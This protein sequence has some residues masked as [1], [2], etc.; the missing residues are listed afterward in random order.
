[1]PQRIYAMFFLSG[2]GALVFEN[3]WF[4]QTGLIVGNSVWSAALVVGAFMLG[5]ALGNAAAIPL[6]RRWRNLVRG[7]AAV[8]A[9]AALSGAL[10]VLAFPALPTLFRPLLAPL[11]DAPAML[12]LVR[13]A[14]AFCLMVIPATALG[15]TLPFLSKPLEALTGNYGSAIGRLYGVNTLGAVA[16]TLLAERFLI[17]SLG[18]LGGGLFAAACNL[19]AAFIALRL[20]RHPAF[21]APLSTDHG[22]RALSTTPGKRIVLAAFLAGGVLLALEVVWFRFLLLFQDGTTWNFAVML[23]V[24]LG[25]IGLGGLAASR[26]A[27]R[28]WSGGRAA[29]AAAAGAAVL[30]VAAYAAFDQ[31]LTLRAGPVVLSLFLMGPV[32]FLSGVLFTALADLLRERM[33][34][35]GAA[36]GVLTLANTLGATLGSLLAAF[37]LLPY[38]GLE[39]SFFLL[40]LSYG[41]TLVVIPGEAARVWRLGPALIVLVA[42]AL[43]PFGRM[44]G[45]YYGRV[46]E[47]FAGRLVAA[48]EGIE[49]TVFYLSHEFLG[50]PL[51]L[52]LATN[53]YSMAST[54]V[55]VQRYMKLFAYLPAAFHPRIER[56]LLLCFGVGTTASALTD[57]P[58][59]RSIDVVDTSRDIVE[60]SE[61]AHPERH[62]LRDPRVSVHIEDARFFLQQTDRRYDLITGEPP[63]PK[64]AGVTALYTRE[65]FALVKERLNPGGL[66]TYW[67]P[68]HLLLESEALSIIRAFCE[69][70]DDCSLWSG[71]N[72][73]WILAGSRDGI[74]P[75]SREHFSRL[76]RL[77][78]PASELRR[79]GIDRPEQL[80]G[81]FMADA[82]AL[83]ELT[84]A[85]LPLADN[86]PRRVT[87]ALFAERSTAR[88]AWLMDPGR[89]RERMLASSWSRILPASLVSESREGFRRRAILE[90]AFYPELR[91]PGYN[92]WS[93][94]AELIRGTDL[95]DLPRWLLGSGARAAEIA[96]RTGP[97]D[98]VAAEHRAIDA[99]ANRRP[100]DAMEKGRFMALTPE[101]QRVVVFHHCLAGDPVQARALM[102]SIPAERRLDALY[103]SLLSWADRQCAA[104]RIN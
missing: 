101:A 1:M 5:L 71:L 52:R 2:V 93:D 27:R 90:Q 37:V 26:W 92:F 65:Y 9:V 42:L 59:V 6:A 100:A 16:G 82:G 28:G 15:A 88:Y 75:V 76:W 62:P 19:S 84:A 53:S 3:V 103:L 96:A 33:N 13:L 11:L 94:V 104:L 95:V 91:Q 23:A 18:L 66:A 72:L 14:V 41:L 12:T 38:A 79:L 54:A 31:A 98:P 56:V 48:R 21:D 32:A 4:S 78:G 10:L 85:S 29:R 81:Q 99:L 44:A 46:E 17:P 22:A 80:V 30:T 63:P 39:R 73:D 24:V 43:F 49:Q 50:E 86:F 57:L 51:F 70:F 25:G 35:A 20:A 64:M 89:S 97:S 102:E 74:A 47:R 58:D 7:Y 45:S 36:T 77:A 83:R 55:G 60:M 61:I 34:D 68:A 40:A 8:E 67:L 87:S 69:A